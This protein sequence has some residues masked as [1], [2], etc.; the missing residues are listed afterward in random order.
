M[1]NSYLD[2]KISSFILMFSLLQ[3]FVLLN[4]AVVGFRYSEEFSNSY[5]T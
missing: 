2:F 4:S 1:I 3:R 5:V